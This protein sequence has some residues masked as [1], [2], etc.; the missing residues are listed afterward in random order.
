MKTKSMDAIL[1]EL[2]TGGYCDLEYAFDAKDPQGQM[3]KILNKVKDISK[4]CARA[5]HEG[6][7]DVEIAKSTLTTIR[8]TTVDNGKL[9]E[10]KEDNTEV[11]GSKII[12]YLTA[13]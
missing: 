11:H 12:V 3:T 5:G 1:W 9:A 8:K 4:K 13:T 7:I 6:V 2:G 10:L